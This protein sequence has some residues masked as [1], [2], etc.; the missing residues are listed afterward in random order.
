MNNEFSHSYD[1]MFSPDN[2]ISTYKLLSS[3]GNRIK[4]SKR[5]QVMY[6]YSGTIGPTWT[7]KFKFNG[8]SEEEHML[9]CP[10]LKSNPYQQGSV[11][12]RKCH[13]LIPLVK[14]VEY[15]TFKYFE[16]SSSQ[17]TVSSKSNS[18]QSTESICDHAAFSKNIFHPL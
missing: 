18:T 16:D 6:Q 7:P 3:V 4:T 2:I 11:M 8:N 14:W 12:M 13:W 1:C 10:V 15:L 17:L 5:G 9:V